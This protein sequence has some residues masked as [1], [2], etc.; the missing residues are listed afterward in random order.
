MESGGRGGEGAK[1]EGV[2]EG[3]ESEGDEESG[4]GG[5]GRNVGGT[6]VRKGRYE[7]EY[8]YHQAGDAGIKEFEP[9]FRTPGA[10]AS[11]VNR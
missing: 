10:I 5:K 1:S 6:K 7:Y 3:D 9:E 8:C 2:R 11:E 4:T